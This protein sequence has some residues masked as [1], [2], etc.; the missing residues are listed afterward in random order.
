M[1]FETPSG[2]LETQITQGI[3]AGWTGRDRAAVDHHI[4]ELADLGVAPPSEVPLFYRV[5]QSL[6]TQAL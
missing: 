3:V 5:S 6:F 1:L 4:A 2:P